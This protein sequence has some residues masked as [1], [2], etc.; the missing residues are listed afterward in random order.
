[1]LYFRLMKM[2]KRGLRKMEISSRLILR[3]VEVCFVRKT[4]YLLRLIQFWWL[5]HWNLGG[6]ETGSQKH[7]TWQCPYRPRTK[8]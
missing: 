4:E 7:G 8:Q 3:M 5:L 6:Q 2:M 1:M